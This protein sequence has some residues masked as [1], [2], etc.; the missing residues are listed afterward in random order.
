MT[1]SSGYGLTDTAGL[2]AP[3]AKTASFRDGSGG[4]QIGANWNLSGLLP[5]NQALSL[6]TFYGYEGSNSTFGDAPDLG[7]VG[8]NIGSLR[9][10]AHI[11]GSSLLY[12]HGTLYAKGTAT[13]EIGHGDLTNNTDNSTGTFS[14]RGYTA[15]LRLGKVFTLFQGTSIA[16]PTVV[17]KAPPKPVPTYVVGL[18]LS[19]HLGYVDTRTGEFTDSGGFRYGSEKLH[20]GEAGVRAKLFGLVPGRG[21]LWMP[22][23]AGTVDQR[24]GFSHIATFPDQVQLVGGD[25]VSYSQ[26]QT[27]WGVEGGLD[28][29]NGGVSG[30]RMGAKG[31]YAASSDTRVSGAQLYFE[32]PLY[33]GAPT[34]R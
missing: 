17:T 10:D 4:G 33:Q 19:G 12:R 8:L 15:D 6:R 34:L 22:Y 25:I 5:S 3:G 2:L 11:F 20:Y 7:I 16:R 23:V 18:D 24:L 31:F 21:V 9:Q 1:H 13:I 32:T 27:F 29:L 30:W 26:A 28:V 14:T